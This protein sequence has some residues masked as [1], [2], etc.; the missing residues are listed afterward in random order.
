[1]TYDKSLG[2]NRHSK[3]FICIDT[4]QTKTQFL[5]VPLDYRIP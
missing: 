1:M 2:M 5:M 4:S 3:A